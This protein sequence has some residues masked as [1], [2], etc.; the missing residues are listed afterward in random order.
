MKKLFLTLVFCFMYLTVWAGCGDT[1]TTTTTPVERS[2][3]NV[4]TGSTPTIDVVKTDNSLFLLTSNYTVYEKNASTSLAQ[5]TGTFMGQKMAIYNYI[6]GIVGIYRDV[7]NLGVSVRCFAITDHSTG[8]SSVIS[9]KILGTVGVLFND[10]AINSTGTIAVIA[11]GNS[12]IW[13]VNITNPASPTKIGVFDTPGNALAVALNSSGTIAYVADGNALQIVSLSNPSAPTAL[14]R[15]VNGSV[16]NDVAVVGNIVCLGD[17]NGSGMWVADVSNP[18]APLLK[19]LVSLSGLSYRVAM[20]SNSPTTVAVLSSS[21]TLGDQI[22]IWNIANPA[23]PIRSSKV[24]VANCGIAK[25]MD[26]KSGYVY[27]AVGT[28]GVYVYKIP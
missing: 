22:E 26:I 15:M 8:D 1:T 9:G 14:G 21:S 6:A 13:V 16:L 27:V 5:I 25:G 2:I 19:S 11:C 28:E 17:Q 7:N 20:D 23:V 24:R 3:I 4:L 10:V 12:G 18:S